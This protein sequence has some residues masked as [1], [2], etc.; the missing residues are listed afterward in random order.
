MPSEAAQRVELVFTLFEASRNG[1]ADSDGPAK[2]AVRAAFRRY[3][4]TLEGELDAD[5]AWAD[6]IRDFHAPD[7]AGIPGDR[8]VGTPAA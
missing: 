6:G 5:A 8:L 1:A 4:A 7:Q 2:Q 3:R